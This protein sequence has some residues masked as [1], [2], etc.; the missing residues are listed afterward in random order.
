MIEY[1][2]NNLQQL[3]QSAIAIAQLAGDEILSYY[4]NT[5]VENDIKIKDDKSPVTIAD[6]ASSKIIENK[7]NNLKI[8]NSIFRLPVLSEESP[9]VNTITRRQWNDYWLVDPLD[10]TKEYIDKNGEFCI[11]ISLISDKRPIIGIIYAPYLKT[12]YYAIKNQGAYKVTAN[13]E[14]TKINTNK[15]DM[16]KKNIT[17]VTSKR[18]HNYSKYNDF[19]DTLRQ[20]NIKTNVILQGSAIKFGLVA[21]GKADI[22]PRFGLT[23]EWDTAAG[24]CILQEAGGCLKTLDGKSFLYNNKDSL[25]NS[26]FYAAGDQHYN[27]RDLIN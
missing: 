12:L 27:W 1:N 10:G 25:L 13:K 23:S 6:L 8:D 17:I 21:E 22:Y 5:K 9:D 20:N 11:I 19:I 16:S 4:N 15:I 14:P 24:D 26:E 18:H 3:C 7:L 2:A